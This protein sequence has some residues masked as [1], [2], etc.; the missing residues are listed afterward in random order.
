MFRMLTVLITILWGGVFATSIIDISGTET[1]FK[2]QQI[3]VVKIIV[4]PVAVSFLCFLF[5]FFLH[6]VGY[7]GSVNAYT[8]KNISKAVTIILTKSN[9]S[10]IYLTKHLAEILFPSISL[11]YP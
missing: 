7:K 2:I 3:R 8:I 4:I 6:W 5:T 1:E 9:C 11:M 10:I